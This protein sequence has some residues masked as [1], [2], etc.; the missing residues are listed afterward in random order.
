[1]GSFHK[2]FAGKR[3]FVTGH[4]GFKGS[5]LCEWLLGLDAEVWGYSLP[6]ATKPALFRQLGLARRL[7]HTVGDVRNSAD[8]RKAI[9]AARPDYVFHLAAQPIVR[10][11]H[12]HPASTW[13]TNVMGTVNLLEALRDLRHPCSAVIVTTD[14][15][16]GSLASAHS[17][18]DPLGAGDPY[19]GSKA[20]A[21]LAVSAWRHSFFPGKGP[22]GHFPR[23]ALATARAGNVLGGGDWAPDRLLPDC[24]RA[25]SRRRPIVLRSPSAV[26]PWQHVLDP[27]AGYLVLGAELRKALTS[28]R[29]ARLAELSGPFNF[30][31]SAR[32]HRPVRDVVAEILGRWPGEWRQAKDS[33]GPEETAVLRLD[34]TKAKRVLGWEPKWRFAKSV[35]RTVDWYRGAVS[36]RKAAQLTRAQIGEYS[37]LN[38]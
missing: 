36:P 26:R 15:V 6:P 19:G 20:A 27:L 13:S 12:S 21:E 22:G 4:T 28:R 23:V 37:A 7:N 35:A 2:A 31:P 18:D 25:L 34:A 16:Y 30:G 10:R 9:S 24:V 32:D 5:W 17:E 11:S 29:R 14:K 3:V 38:R 1:M 8:L 33:R